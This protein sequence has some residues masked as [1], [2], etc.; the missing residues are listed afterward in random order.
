MDVWHVG[1]QELEQLLSWQTKQNC[2]FT[3]DDTS[4]TPVCL[5]LLHLAMQESEAALAAAESEKTSL[6]AQLSSGQTALADRDAALDALADEL[7]A[8]SGLCDEQT[9]AKEQAEEQVRAGLCFTLGAGSGHCN[10]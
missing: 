7:V 4:V 2:Y 8:V 3:W 6:S 10:T 5:Y 1:H 9:A